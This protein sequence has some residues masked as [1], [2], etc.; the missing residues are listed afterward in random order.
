MTDPRRQVVEV[1]MT[2][3]LPNLVYVDRVI[4]V[5]DPASD[6]FDVVYLDTPDLRLARHSVTLCRV[7]GGDDPGWW[8]EI[9]DDAGPPTRVQQPLG[10]ST[11]VPAA[12]ARRL[13]AVVRRDP[14]RRVVTLH[15]A[16]TRC[17]LLDE[18]GAVLATVSDDVVR[19]EPAGAQG[20][21]SVWRQVTTTVLVDDPDLGDAVHRRLAAAGLHPANAPPV[22]PRIFGERLPAAAAL[23]PDASSGDVLL[24]Y[25]RRQ[26]D[27]LIREDARA[28]RDERDAVHRMRVA[29][30]RLRASLASY[31][32]L[33]ERSR[34]EPIRDELAW[35]GSVLGAPRDAEVVRDRLRRQLA[36]LAPELVRGPV[37]ERIELETVARH[38][39]AHAEL[40]RALDSDRFLD[41]LDALDELTIRPPLLDAAN[42]PARIGLVRLVRDAAR[43]VDRIAAR[44]E[45]ITEPSRREAALH[46]LRRAAKRAR[47]AAELAAP[48]MGRPA[49]R[50]AEAM[51]GIQEVLGEYQDSVTARPVIVGLATAAREAG[52]DAFTF[53]VL[54]GLEQWRG[55][56]AWARYPRAR[57]AAQRGAVRRWLG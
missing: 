45:R 54:Y 56:R 27:A 21:T 33:I 29:T 5:T 20:P 2:A 50:L 15:T 53:G 30:R 24:A 14:L 55:E 4:G 26:V 48:A 39:T 42:S 16:R 36:E 12:L 34:T 8:L 51:E 49:T 40:V 19:A 43:R 57:K 9:A 28:R 13:R 11:R 32:P 35:L 7:T 1:S 10:R 47:Y 46:D 3:P 44:A 22:I 17:D 37:A 31:R 52:E 25:L 38:A 23:G 41:L 18:S 6:K